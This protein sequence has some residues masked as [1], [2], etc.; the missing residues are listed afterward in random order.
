[1][2][3][4]AFRA[5][6]STTVFLALTGCERLVV[7]CPG[8]PRPAFKVTVTDS[9][10]GLGAWKDASLIIANT[11]HYD[12]ALVV[13]LGTSPTA[14]TTQALEF[15][16]FGTQQRGIFDV[17]VRK[18]GYELWERSAIGVGGRSCDVNAVAISVRLRRSGSAE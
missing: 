12:S 8:L 13:F 16:S 4:C 18:E 2:R 10:T 1:M 17:R 9:V 14:D 7:A 15:S 11:E 5:M 3:P 6:L